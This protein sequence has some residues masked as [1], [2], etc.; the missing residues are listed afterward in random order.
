MDVV[1]ENLLRGFNATTGLVTGT[2]AG[3]LELGQVVAD[4]GIDIGKGAVGLVGETGAAATMSTGVAIK[5][6]AQAV[7]AAGII[8]QTATGT[9]ANA[10]KGT[11]DA[12]SDS[13]AQLNKVIT[14]KGVKITEAQI[15]L[16]KAALAAQKDPKNIAKQKAVETKKRELYLTKQEFNNKRLEL[17]QRTKAEVD[18]LSQETKKVQ[19]TIKNE[20]KLVNA[21]ADAEI[22]KAN[23]EKAINKGHAYAT[24]IRADI[25]RDQMLA[26]R[27]AECQGVLLDMKDREDENGK[28][29]GVEGPIPQNIAAQKLFCR[30]KLNCHKTGNRGRAFDAPWNTQKFCNKLT[31]RYANLKEVHG[32]ATISGGKKRKTFKR[33]SKK[34]GYSIKQRK[35]RKLKNVR[36][37]VRESV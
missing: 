16:D 36:K 17:L 24:V 37:S 9:T 2:T 25:K 10:V 27:E 7:A 13:V 32:K 23:F 19:K 12:V 1:K 31:R 6:A 18:A 5:T 15:A 20:G 8:T 3:V 28:L 33:K 29:V 22:A 11:A 35:S 4:T 30:E 14:A 34:K 26:Q 21:K